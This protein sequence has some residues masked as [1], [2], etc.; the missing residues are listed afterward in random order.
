VRL[1]IGGDEL[2]LKKGNIASRIEGFVVIFTALSLGVDKL[3]T[4][5]IFGHIDLSVQVIALLISSAI[6]VMGV[7]IVGR[8]PCNY[9]VALL[10]MLLMLLMSW[11]LFEGIRSE[12]VPRVMTYIILLSLCSILYL[13]L[14]SSFSGD[15]IYRA[16]RKI[17]FYGV[18]IYFIIFA[19]YVYTLLTRSQEVIGNRD[20]WD[21]G[22][23]DVYEVQYGNIIAFQGYSGDPNALGLGVAIVLFCG[24]SF[25]FIKYDFLRHI[26]NFVLILMILASNSRGAMVALMA[27]FFVGAL[28]L[29]QK[30]YRWYLSLLMFGIGA[31]LIFQFK[32]VGLSNPVGKISRGAVSRFEQ[33]NTILE[34][35]SVKPFIGNG[36]RHSEYLLGKYTENSYLTLLNDT[37]VIGLLLYLI[38]IIFPVFLFIMTGRHKQAG[39]SVVTP[40]LV[41][42]IFLFL[43]MMYIS[44]EVKPI[45]WVVAG[46]IAGSYF[47]PIT[48]FR[49][50]RV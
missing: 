34:S 13:R 36:L 40:W 10:L 49:S 9:Q 6:V 15:V 1:K 47:A 31:L 22:S 19:D 2:L 44:M 21:V 42:S 41:Y 24:L 35:F 37:G 43:S 11:F 27:A 3:F 39:L 38:V 26:I 28:I 45:L 18:M 48:D 5:T 20:L 14:S 25:K 23:A 12:Q 29:D 50:K 8:V 46:I 7:I 16:N 33:W 30:I 32:S 4:L 17:Y